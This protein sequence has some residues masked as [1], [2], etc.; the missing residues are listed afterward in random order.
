MMTGRK[1]SWCRGGGWR[2]YNRLS[3]APSRTGDVFH[4]GGDMGN[5]DAEVERAEGTSEQSVKGDA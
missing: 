2:M 1:E 5:M 4:G 3:V